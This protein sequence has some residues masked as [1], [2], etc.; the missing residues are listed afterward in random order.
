[1]PEPNRVVVIGAG[2]I[3][4]ITAALLAKSGADVTLVCKH[5]D[6]AT[7]A[8]GR[9]LHITGVQGE[10][11]I[12]VHAVAAIEELSGTFSIALIATKAYDMPDAAR[13]LL[14][15]LTPDTMVLSLQN[16][17]CTD[18]LS[19]VVGPA[20]T[21][22]CVI[23][24]GATMH[25]PADLE[26][27]STGDFI[28]GRI[29]G[30]QQA[31]GPAK[32]V[33]EGMTKT[34]V[35]DNILAEL[36]SK[37]IVNSCITSL[38]AICGL[39]LGEMLRRRQ[40]RK[41]FL[42]IVS[43]AMAVAD[44]MKITVPS[45]GGKL[46]YY[47]LLKGKGPLSDFRRHATIRVIGIKYR[48][49]TSSS[50]QSLRRGRPTEIDYFNGYIAGKGEVLGVPCPINKRLTEMVKAIEGHKRSIK[51]ENLFDPVFMALK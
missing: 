51:E 43:E 25:G 6:I 26:M 39:K 27:T 29:E 46:N 49:L 18:A 7:L 31:L 42:A 45:F 33:L 23:G 16:G 3:G 47:Q 11:N 10:Q 50:L 35:T 34:I 8:S 12:P 37:L 5:Q 32:A 21:V 19:A 38:G 22:G 20:R 28:I 17:L 15:F 9:G 2:A 41:I 48:N 24:W 30:D 1:M 40:A 36:Y 13:K 4:G 14:P 44:A